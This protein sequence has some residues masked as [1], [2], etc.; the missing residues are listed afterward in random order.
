MYK[1]VIAFL[2]FTICFSYADNSNTDKFVPYSGEE[3]IYE[4]SY[5]G[6]KLGTIKIIT[7]N[8]KKETNKDLMLTTAYIDTYKGI[9]FVDIHVVYQ[10]FTD[11]SFG[12]S[13]RFIGNFK[14]GDYTDLQKIFFNYDKANIYISK[15]N[16]NGKYFENSIMTDKKVSDG[17]S[18]FFFARKFLDIHKSITIPTVVDK[19]LVSTKINFKSTPENVTVPCIKYPVKAL[20]FDGIAYWTGVYGLSGEFEGWFTNDAARIPLKAKMKLYVGSVLIELKSW[21]RQGWVAPKSDS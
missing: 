2:F 12:F 8:H 10:S 11:I 16:A 6:I 1:L 20:Y 7:G 13:H 14:S 3:L 9:P 4:V 5:M 19:E 17:L 21:K 15:E 18:I